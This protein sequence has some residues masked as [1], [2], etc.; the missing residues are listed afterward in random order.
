[1]FNNWIIHYIHNPIMTN[2]LIDE[3]LD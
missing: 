3:N 1:M 2:R